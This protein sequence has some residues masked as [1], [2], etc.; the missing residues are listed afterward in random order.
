M[1]PAERSRRR[2]QSE[3]DRLRQGAAQKSKNA[4]DFL[5]KTTP[6]L[7]PA[8]P[9]VSALPEIVE[10]TSKLT[11]AAAAL[12]GV[13]VGLNAGFDAADAYKRF[14][15]DDYVGGTISTAAS[16]AGAAAVTGLVLGTAV[17]SAPAV[18][19]LSIAAAALGIGNLLLDSVKSSDWWAKKKEQASKYSSTSEQIRTTPIFDALGNVIDMG[20]NTSVNFLATSQN[21]AIE[22]KLKTTHYLIQNN[23]NINNTTTN[24]YPP[25]R[26]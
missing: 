6:P 23:V 14:Q 25:R 26:F 9:S 21:Q 15:R 7:P 22:K 16:I 20:N 17:L 8:K 1:T 2:S 4:Q 24:V 18:T 12:N 3:F 11:K 10:S 13:F 5:R 19:A